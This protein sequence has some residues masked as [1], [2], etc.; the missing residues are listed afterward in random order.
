M[1]LRSAKR[2]DID[3][4]VI[5][6]KQLF[7]IEQD[8]TFDRVKQKR[9]LG[10]LLDSDSAQVFVAEVAGAVIGMVSGQLVISTAE[11]GYSL[12]IEDMVVDRQHRGNGVGKTLLQAAGD[13][14][15]QRGA[16]RLQ[17]LADL[18]NSR[19]F[20]FYRRAA[21]DRTNLVCFRKYNRRSAN[22]YCADR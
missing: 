7:S 18:D 1:K 4:L 12:L 21:W 14:A 22:E 16:R 15:L 9:G 6:L 20:S 3:E 10:L 5:L 19:A 2:E 13:W 8:F 11:G 17:L